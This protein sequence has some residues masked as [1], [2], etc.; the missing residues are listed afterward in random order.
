MRKHWATNGE[1]L[2][3]SGGRAHP[4]GNKGTI[5]VSF[6]LEGE[7]ITYNHHGGALVVSGGVD[8]WKQIG[9]AWSHKLLLESVRRMHLH[10]CLICEDDLVCDSA[11]E[12]KRVMLA[13]IA[14]MSRIFPTWKLLLLGGTPI[15]YGGPPSSPCG[16]DGLHFAM[17]VII[18]R[19][20]TLLEATLTKFI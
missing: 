1:E 12:A 18:R 19:T 14:T 17:T 2:L 7:R 6:T 11:K 13:A 5:R 16:V 4:V 9:C 15:G 8:V 3:Q 10:A 20:L